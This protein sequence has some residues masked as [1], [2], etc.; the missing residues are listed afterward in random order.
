MAFNNFDDVNGVIIGGDYGQC[1]VT[2]DGRKQGDIMYA[3]DYPE[4]DAMCSSVVEQL[5][6][7]LGDN[8]KLIYPLEK[9][10][11]HFDGI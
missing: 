1:W 4:A 5:K 3:Q 11:F 6:A 9:W 2:Y 10:R 8:F 7:E